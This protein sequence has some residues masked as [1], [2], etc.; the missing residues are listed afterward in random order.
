MEFAE[1]TSAGDYAEGYQEGEFSDYNAC[2]VGSGQM[3]LVRFGSGMMDA[4]LRGVS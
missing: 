1:G 4:G 3:G 2:G